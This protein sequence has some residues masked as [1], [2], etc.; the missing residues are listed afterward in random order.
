MLERIGLGFLNRVLRAPASTTGV[1]AAYHAVVNQARRGEFYQY[2]GVPDTLDGRFDLLVLHLA[3]VAHRLKGGD[4]VARTWVRSLFERFIADMDRNLREMGVGDLSVGRKVKA[5]A[6][7]LNGRLRSYDLALTQGDGDTTLEIALD[8]NL[9]GTILTCPADA[10]AAMVAYIRSA[11]AAL[12]EQ[13]GERVLAGELHFPAPPG[14]LPS[15]RA[16]TGQGE[17]ST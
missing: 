10:M 15:H 11:V 13:P 5:M 7:A 6:H 14:P 1:D 12:A 9:Y 17:A 4:G 8:N 3:L 16:G 2:A